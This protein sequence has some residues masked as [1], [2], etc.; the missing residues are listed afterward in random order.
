M[1]RESESLHK[2][3]FSSGLILVLDM[4]D[5]LLACQNVF[6]QCG[7]HSYPFLHHTKIPL[8]HGGSSLISGA[9]ENGV[10]PNIPASGIR[11]YNVDDRPDTLMFRPG[12]EPVGWEE[13]WGV[14]MLGSIGGGIAYTA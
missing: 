8:P 11:G 4:G 2:K 5:D 13:M 10:L 12:V 9:P 14:G 3:H 6:D 7:S 1:T